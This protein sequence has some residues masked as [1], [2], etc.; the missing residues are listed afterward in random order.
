MAPGTGLYLDE[1]FYDGYNNRINIQAEH[2]ANREKKIRNMTKEDPAN[3]QVDS[4]NDEDDEDKNDRELLLW[5]N[6]PIVN[7]KLADYR[8]NVVWPHIYL[9]EQSKLEFVHHLDFLRVCPV[10][11]NT[12]TVIANNQELS[13]NIE[14]DKS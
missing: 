6:D 4:I 14:T 5:T 8:E 9:L 13:V 2:D 11:F 12:K 1:L 10:T 3:L 7:S